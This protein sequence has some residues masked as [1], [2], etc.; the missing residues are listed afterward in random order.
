MSVLPYLSSKNVT[1]LYH[2][3][4]DTFVL[5]RTTERMY[6]GQVLDI[7]KKVQNSRH[8]SVGEA[9]SLLGLSYLS[10]RVFLPIGISEV[11][12][13]CIMALR[14]LKVV[15][16]ESELIRIQTTSYRYSLARLWGTGIICVHMHPSP[17][18]CITLGLVHFQGHLDGWS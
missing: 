9:H 8:G 14:M 17:M 13:L 10:L 2:L 6:I 16:G 7:Y 1:S 15:Q 3:V 11:P 18:S 12:L 4:P 5:M